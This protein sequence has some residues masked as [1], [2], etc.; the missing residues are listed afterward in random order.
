MLPSLTL[1]Y[2]LLLLPYAS[3][4]HDEEPSRDGTP[5]SAPVPHAAFPYLVL[6]VLLLADASPSHVEEPSRDGAPFSAP[7]RYLHG[8]SLRPG[9]RRSY[10]HLH[11]LWSHHRNQME[12]LMAF[13][14]LK[15]DIIVCC[16]LPSYLPPG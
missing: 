3:P 1:Y 8:H 13:A 11:L 12:H 9:A 4:S 14:V 5:V 16:R 7:V 2:F 6:I 10:R 15:L